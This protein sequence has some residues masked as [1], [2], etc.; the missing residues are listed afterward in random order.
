MDSIFYDPPSS[1]RRA[2]ISTSKISKG[3]ASWS[4]R[5]TLLGWDIDTA[6]MTMTLPPHRQTRL[7]SILTD[8]SKKHRI[9]RRN[10]Q[11]LLG[12]LRNMALAISGAKFHFSLL[13]NA[14][15]QQQGVS[16][17]ALK[18]RFPSARRTYR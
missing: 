4:T 9:S 15:V 10:W 13:Q 11:Q 12:E 6:T 14:L 16:I 17:Y 3:D 5:K 7:L 18:Y 8:G 2:V 1:V